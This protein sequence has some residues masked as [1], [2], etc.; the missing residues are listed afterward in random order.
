MRIQIRMQLGLFPSFFVKMQTQSGV[1]I[2]AIFTVKNMNMDMYMD[3]HA[4]T[5]MEKSQ[6]YTA[7]GLPAGPPR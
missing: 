3:E 2:L 1:R 7:P 5:P 6:K 4:W